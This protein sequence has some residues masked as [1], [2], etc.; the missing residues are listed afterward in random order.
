MTQ[1]P[2]P[3]D[4]SAAPLSGLVGENALRA[5]IWPDSESRPSR[6]W[7]LELKARG[8]IPYHR[9]GRRVFFDPAEV[10]ASLDHNFR[11]NPRRRS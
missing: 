2:A 6:R 4:S 11:I 5:T 1:I 3:N 9:I 7:F 8:L 10:R